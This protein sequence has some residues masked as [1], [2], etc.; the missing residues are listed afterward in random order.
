MEELVTVIVPVYNIRER[1]A[2]C[3]DS[4]TNQTHGALQIVL[5]D[6]GSTDGSGDL[7]DAL[8]AQDARI[9]VIHRVNGGASAAR[10]T[11][12]NRVRGEWI[13]FVDS[14]DYVSPYYIEDMLAAAQGDCDM[15]VCHC[16]WVPDVEDGPGAQFGRHSRSQRITGRE[17]CVRN[18]G[19]DVVLL[20]TCWGKLFRAHLWE[21]LRYPEGK[22]V[23]EDLFV[24]HSLFYR[25]GGIAI[26][27]AVLY[28]YVQ[29]E[30]S[31]M[32]REFTAQRLDVLDA[33]EEA[34]R[35]FK[36]AGEPDIENIAR[37][38]YCTRVFNAR[39]VCK[40]LIPHESEVL[41]Q[42]RLRSIEAYREAKPIRGYIDFSVSKALA[43]RLKLFLGR[44]CLPL[45][46]FLF[47]R[48]REYI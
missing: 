30:G 21:G 32:R 45:Y 3:V 13:A 35:F 7:C 38:V 47:M 20:I 1:I 42:L 43:Y 40:K 18:F 46:D 39:C 22:M 24:S 9:E 15:A 12:L 6:D 27:D 26:T 8:A 16:V 5:V 17:A 28:A 48:G 2:R 4:I 41:S 25:A 10:N 31:L 29:S 33:W 23:A 11:G 19:G 44:W 34:V 36:A 37:R 14:D